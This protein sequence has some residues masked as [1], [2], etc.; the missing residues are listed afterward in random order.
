MTNVTS[1]LVVAVLLDRLQGAG[2]ERRLS[3]G[4]S[5]SDPDGI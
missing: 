1:D 4:N 2:P 5:S 3:D